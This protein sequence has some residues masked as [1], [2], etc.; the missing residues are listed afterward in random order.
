M[1]PTFVTIKPKKMIGLRTKTSLN[2]QAEAIQILWPAFM[3]KCPSIGHRTDDRLYS[4]Q[5]FDPKDWPILADSL[6]EKWAAVEVNTFSAVPE[7]FETMTLTGGLY[8]VFVYQGLPSMAPYHYI[9]QSWLPSSGYTLDQ[10]E[11]FEIMDSHYRPDDPEA[12]EEIWIPVK[13][14]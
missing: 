10:R 7:G 11:Q 9:F 12:T 8:A 13:Q 14:K 6:F 2:V 4:I 3:K 1:D 5:I